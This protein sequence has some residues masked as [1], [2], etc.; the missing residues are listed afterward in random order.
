MING[1][2]VYKYCSINK[3]CGTLFIQGKIRWHTLNTTPKRWKAFP[4]GWLSACVRLQV[5]GKQRVLLRDFVQWINVITLCKS[6]AT[7]YQHLRY[8]E[9][10][11]ALLDGDRSPCHQVKNKLLKTKGI[12]SPVGMYSN[13]VA[14]ETHTLTQVYCLF[15]NYAYANEAAFNARALDWT[16]SPMKIEWETVAIG[17]NRENVDKLNIWLFFWNVKMISTSTTVYLKSVW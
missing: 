10:N 17:R 5:V 2:L 1:I 11:M 3:K 4:N 7:P 14:W 12:I 9:K 8:L 13:V 16:A 6:G 15:C